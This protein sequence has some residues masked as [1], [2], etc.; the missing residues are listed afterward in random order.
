MSFFFITQDFPPET[1]GIQTYTYEHAKELSKNG[2]HVIVIAPYKPQ[3][4]EWDEKQNFE[5][6]RFSISNSLLFIPLLFKLPFLAKKQKINTVIHAQWQTI[7]PSLIAKKLGI[8]KNFVVSVHARELLF[9]PFGSSLLG[10]IYNYYMQWLLSKADLLFPVST[11]TKKLLIEIGIDEEKIKVIINGTDPAR[12]YP[13]D[14]TEKRD[15]MNLNGKYVILTV[16]RLVQ[17]KGIDTVIEALVKFKNDKIDFQYLIVGDGPDREELEQLTREKG[18]DQMVRFCGKVPLNELNTYYNLCDLFV[19]PSKTVIPDVEGFGI[20]FLEANACA[21][22][23]IGSDSGGIP[24][25][26]THEKTGLIV[27][28]NNPKELYNAILRLY[29]NQDLAYS[30]GIQGLQRVKLEANWSYL[31][32]QLIQH[33]QHLNKFNL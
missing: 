32:K 25:A 31:S 11:Y 7:L 2:R 6:L 3:S 29:E 13:I 10:Y 15:K 30:L 18:I 17:R 22:P 20:V 28:E 21:K 24:S 1:G 26:I 27:R 4:S 9:N 23:V 16:S 33:L 5:V 14:V 19:L 8:I 12:Y